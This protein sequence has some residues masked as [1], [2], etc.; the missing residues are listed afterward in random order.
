MSIVVQLQPL[1]AESTARPD[2]VH[3]PDMSLWSTQG[4]FNAMAP[5][6]PGMSK[7]IRTVLALIGV[8]IGSWLLIKLL[9]PHSAAEKL[10]EKVH[11]NV[12]GQAAV[13]GAVGAAA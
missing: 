13:T 7:R 8:V 5:A 12:L 1:L 2:E 6:A 11:P 3:V 10:H 9:A 4:Y